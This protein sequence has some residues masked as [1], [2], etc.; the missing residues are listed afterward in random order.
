MSGSSVSKRQIRRKRPKPDRAAA[1]TR[2]LHGNYTRK[3]CRTWLGFMARGCS[4]TVFLC[5]FCSKDL[6]RTFLEQNG[7]S[8]NYF[9]TNSV[10]NT[11]ATP[12]A[13]FFHH[14]T[15]R[16]QDGE[17]HT[18]C[19][20]RENNLSIFNIFNTS[21]FGCSPVSD[22]LSA[23]ELAEYQVCMQVQVNFQ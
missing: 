7:R 4:K 20:H 17:V 6:E 23:S 2:E 13:S 1:E 5:L 16:G 8:Q 11:L 10:L 9:F 18:R 14:I 12:T 21:V 3:A 22:L 19:I 15:S